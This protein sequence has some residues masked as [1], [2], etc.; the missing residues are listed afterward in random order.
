MPADFP[1]ARA[2][3]WRETHAGACRWLSGVVAFP[4]GCARRAPKTC[5]TRRS[6]RLPGPGRR[7]CAGRFAPWVA[8]RCCGRQCLVPPLHGGERTA[9][10][11]AAGAHPRLRGRPG[12]RAAGS[13]A[14]RDAPFVD[15]AR[16][17]AWNWACPRPPR[18]SVCGRRGLSCAG[19]RGK[20]G[21]C[22]RLSSSSCSCVCGA[23]GCLAPPNQVAPDELNELERAFLKESLRQ[24]R[25]LQD[26]LRGRYQ[27]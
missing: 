1:C 26:R 3:S 2:G 11:P 6:F 22:Q 25:R 10:R 20:S 15:A 16:I 4:T 19:G 13:Q 23:S 18:W 8:A 24:A 14:R 7:C 21:P 27:L 5:S 12:E 9:Q 17:Y